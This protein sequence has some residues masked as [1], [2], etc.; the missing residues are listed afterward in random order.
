MGREQ[1]K[2]EHFGTTMRFWTNKE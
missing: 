2:S 1:W